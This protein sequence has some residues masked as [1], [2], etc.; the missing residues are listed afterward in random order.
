MRAFGTSILLLA[1]LSVAC[2]DD[3]TSTP[4]AGAG[5]DTGVTLDTGIGDTG[6]TTPDMGMPDTGGAADAGTTMCAP[7]PE[8]DTTRPAGCASPNA[9]YV[10]ATSTVVDENGAEV[11]GAKPQLCVTNSEDSFVCVE[12]VNS[13]DDGTWFQQLPEAQRC[14]KSVVMNLNKPN[15]GFA[16]TYC[17]VELA[18]EGVLELEPLVLYEAE[19]APNLP[20]L[21]DPD[22]VRTVALQDGVEIELAPT[23]FLDCYEDGFGCEGVYTPLGARKID[24]TPCFIDPENAPDA[25]YAFTVSNQLEGGG[26]ELRV[27]NANGLAAGSEVDFYIVGGVQLHL[28]DG[29]EVEEGDWVPF[30]TGTVSADGSTIEGVKLPFLTWFGYKAR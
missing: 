21:G 30:G 12:P 2:G 3:A 14:L 5:S 17:P 13:C 19:A 28:A 10:F 26:A 9:W 11:P 27:P 25:L 23:M 15:A 8:V 18:G 16:N 4:D 22:A 29:T 6:E 24:A 7:D 1:G 20:P